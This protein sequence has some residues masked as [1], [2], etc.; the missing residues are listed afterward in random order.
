ML[1]HRC[2]NVQRQLVRVRIIDRNELD[3]GSGWCIEFGAWDSRKYWRVFSLAQ[4]SR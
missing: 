3:T 4:L 2:Q 1:G